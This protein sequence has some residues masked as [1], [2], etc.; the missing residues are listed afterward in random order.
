LG[1]AVFNDG[2]RIAIINSTFVGNTG[3]GAAGVAGTSGTG[4]LQPHEGGAGGSAL[5]GGLFNLSGT[6]T[7]TNCTFVENL[8]RGGQGGTGG[9]GSTFGFGGDGA[10]G[11]SGGDALGA[12]IYSDAQ[13]ITIAVNNTF[14]DNV[15]VGGPGGNGGPGTGVGNNGGTG[16]QGSQD[17]AALFN[18]GG[19]L[20]L[21]NSILA[22]SS[23]GSNAGGVITD[24]GY[25]LSSD[26]T[27][28]LSA[29]GS[30]NGV[31]PLLGSYTTAGG[32]VPTITLATNSPAVNAIN[33]PDNNGAPPFDQRH[34]LRVA[35]YDIGPYELDGTF[36]A[37]DLQVHLATNQVVLS[38]PAAGNFLAQTT[39]NLV[40]TN[41]W[42]T[43]ADTP[44]TANGLNILVITPTN[45]AS[46]F[47]LAKP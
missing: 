44:T 35:P 45:S 40:P 23:S 11:G 18:G 46:F 2:G 1:G 6:V 21:R 16:N 28:K 22:N 33:T 19:V 43:I 34:A 24:S 4:T 42:V 5:G 32:L 7:L 15:V 3:T 14:T 25:N 39:T 9:A 47:R 10:R 13:A 20:Q 30:R 12:G 26:A 41:Q 29:P 37:P 31:D 36:T 8:M 38:W 27:P 17:G